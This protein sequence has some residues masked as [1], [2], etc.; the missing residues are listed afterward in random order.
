MEKYRCAGE[1]K[2]PALL[3]LIKAFKIL[4]KIKINSHWTTQLVYCFSVETKQF[5]EVIRLSHL[6]PVRQTVP[7]LLQADSSQDPH[8]WSSLHKAFFPSVSGQSDVHLW[9][10]V[11]AHSALPGSIRDITQLIEFP[12]SSRSCFTQVLSYSF[13]YGFIQPWEGLIPES[14]PF[15]LQLPW[16]QWR[17]YYL[18]I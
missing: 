18:I 7:L 9:L 8:R 5:S 6:N 15:V 12:L 16:W 13:H 10:P 4:G 3:V 2:M 14:R 17:L 11:H 1:V